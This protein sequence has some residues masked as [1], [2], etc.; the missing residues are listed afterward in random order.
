MSCGLKKTGSI[1]EARVGFSSS[2]LWSRHHKTHQK[3]SENQL[4]VKLVLSYAQKIW[5][6]KK[7]KKKKKMMMKMMNVDWMM[8][9]KMKSVDLKNDVDEK[10]LHLDHLHR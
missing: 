8:M 7:K 3:K 2:W 10:L 9:K 1:D 6:L 4:D 5:M